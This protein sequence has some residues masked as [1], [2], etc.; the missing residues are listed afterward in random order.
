M[1]LVYHETELTG[2]TGQTR[3]SGA[4]LDLYYCEL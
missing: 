4:R 2:Q 1:A 3:Q